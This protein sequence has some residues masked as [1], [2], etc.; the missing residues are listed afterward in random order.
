MSSL[1]HLDLLPWLEV[2]ARLCLLCL[3]GLTL[4]RSLDTLPARTR[5]RLLLGFLYALLATPLLIQT[6]PRLEWRLL[7]ESAPVTA[8]PVQSTA[9]MKADSPR[10]LQPL[11]PASGDS[12]GSTLD[13]QSALLL[14]WIIGATFI[15]FRMLGEWV[16]L[17]RVTHQAA[18]HQTWRC[19]LDE[20]SRIMQLRHR[21]HLACHREIRTPCTWGLM[22]PSILLPIEA[23]SWPEERIRAI[24]VHEC[25]HIRR[26]D[27]VHNC[28]AQFSLGLY[29]LVPFFAGLVSRL[30]DESEKAVD[31]QV[32]QTGF[33]AIDYA[34][35]LVDVA[36][37]LSSPHRLAHGASRTGDLADR[38]RDLIGRQ[39]STIKDS[40]AGKW[41][42]V[43]A[44]VAV[45]LTTTVVIT[46]QPPSPLLV[47]AL[48]GLTGVDKSTR[49]R[50]IW[51]L[52]TLEHHHGVKP[53]IT[54]LSDADPEIRAL[55]AWALGEIKHREALPSLAEKLT[56]PD[57]AVR[58]ML[59]RAIG[60]HEDA[61]WCHALI[62]LLDDPDASIR[63]A[64][65]WSLGE[66]ALEDTRAVR[67]ELR[68]SFV[69]ALR[70]TMG[71]GDPRV[72]Q[73][74]AIAVGHF[75]RRTPDET[76]TG[77]LGRLLLN[78]PYEE[79]RVTA[80]GQL[81]HAGRDGIGFLVPALG[82]SSHEV[83]R[84]AIIAL[85][86]IGD[87]HAVDALV[88]LVGSPDPQLR[89]AATWALDEIQ[90]PGR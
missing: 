68:P 24:L 47:E 50:A 55:A 29:W 17:H 61:R 74:A 72:R 13:W 34:Q 3:L 4:A 38:L 19:T 9:P 70:K 14:L 52:A 37:D 77:E 44:L 83:K 65:T 62:A 71:D 87:D 39:A 63:A 60:E 54:C 51:T 79:V 16:W 20:A 10:V 40:R 48:D 23:I 28:V 73:Q 64:V 33:P 45:G 53:L 75:L 8:A 90:L 43:L 82:D 25:G 6:L 30:R 11:P 26:R 69:G 2:Y 27:Y 85:G 1:A 80:A 57:P 42:G 81:P 46:R 5:H 49:Q 32:I 18:G 76:L 12:I 41:V 36:R 88:T 35:A 21:P 15:W 84:S 86:R 7:A 56:D 67:D 89:E 58:D 22:R 66:L 59:I 31:Q 78:D